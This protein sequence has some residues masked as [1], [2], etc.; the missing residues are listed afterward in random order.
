MQYYEIFVEQMPSTHVVKTKDL[1]WKIL[2][3]Q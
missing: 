3:E 2:N 1:I